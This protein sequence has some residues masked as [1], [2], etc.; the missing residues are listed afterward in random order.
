MSFSKRTNDGLFVWWGQISPSLGDCFRGNR[1]LSLTWKVGSLIPGPER[2]PEPPNDLWCV[3]LCEIC[4]SKM[5]KCF[6]EPKNKDFLKKKF[7]QDVWLLRRLLTKI[8]VQFVEIYFFATRKLQN[9]WIPF[10]KDK[11]MKVS[12]L[13]DNW[14]ENLKAVNLKL[15]I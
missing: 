12:L 15:V 3:D 9:C 2:C 14:L 4:R 10:I 13:T 7:S 6:L 8:V 11:N 1:I 5:Q